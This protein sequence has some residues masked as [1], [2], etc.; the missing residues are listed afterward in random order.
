MHSLLISN[1][2]LSL[3]LALARPVFMPPQ[4][5]LQSLVH[6]VHIRV[7]CLGVCTG[8]Q[9]DHADGAVVGIL[10]NFSVYDNLIWLD[11]TNEA[12]IDTTGG[13]WVTRG[14][15]FIDVAGFLIH[16]ID[17]GAVLNGGYYLGDPVSHKGLFEASPVFNLEDIVLPVLSV[18]KTVDYLLNAFF[19]NCAFFPDYFFYLL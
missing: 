19:F 15:F 8:L 18:Q 6:Q 12:A 1:L 3:G 9:R 10:G 7:H 14:C 4:P 17:V 5:I 2:N 11:V 13:G 16:L